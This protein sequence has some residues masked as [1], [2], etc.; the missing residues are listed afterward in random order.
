MP[1]DDGDDAEDEE[2]PDDLESEI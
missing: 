2:T 1:G